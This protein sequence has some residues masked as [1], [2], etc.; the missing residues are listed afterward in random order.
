MQALSSLLPYLSVLFLVVVVAVGAVF[1]GRRPAGRRAA[2]QRFARQVGLPLP[3]DCHRLDELLAA[4]NRSIGVGA[5][6]GVLFVA[7]W[8]M[9]SGLVS[10]DES[11]WPFV[12]I[13]AALSGAAVSVGLSATRQVAR[14]LA[15][16]GQL[17]ARPTAPTLDD[18]LAPVEL[19][20]GRIAAVA[21]AVVVLV[22]VVA[23]LA[24][25][26]VAV[27]GVLSPGVVTVVVLSLA[28]L[29]TSEVIGRIVI[30]Q[31]QLAGSPLELA[32]NDAL[33]ARLL[34]DLVTMPITVGSYATFGILVTGS[35]V[36]ESESL[37]IAMLVA[38]G[39]AAIIFLVLGLVS[40]AVRPQ[41]H[42]RRQLWPHL[43]EHK[44]ASGT[45]SP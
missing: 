44:A 37:R 18:Y 9:I 33:R 12:I 34:R 32:W 42:F 22:A 11:W 29:T 14:P 27:G 43:L 13:G 26:V 36:L 4:R 1:V 23:G 19:Q 41:R 35:R 8:T 24:S 45:G 5:V 31:S 2:R 39:V 3:D 15:D 7:I 28:A 40:L 38:V 17:L 20:G 30:E 25:P 6:A 10:V 21:P 16:D